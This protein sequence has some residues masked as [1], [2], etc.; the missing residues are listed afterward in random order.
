MGVGT[1]AMASP[2]DWMIFHFEADTACTYV[3]WL[4]FP[5][6]FGVSATPA[7]ALAATALVIAL[8]YLTHLMYLNQ[9]YLR[10]I[11]DSDYIDQSLYTIIV[12]ALY[13]SSSSKPSDKRE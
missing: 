6:L 9:G 1:L 4:M 8:W 5:L 10:V 7:R 13:R 11:Y 12:Y 2:D 3:A